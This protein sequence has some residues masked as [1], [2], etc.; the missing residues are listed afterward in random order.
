MIKT[1]FGVSIECVRSDNGS[2]FI[3]SQVADMFK[4]YGIIQQ[5]SCVY[6]PQQNSVV[7]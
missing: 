5:S 6:S 2:E 4:E 1:Q 7:E 3:N